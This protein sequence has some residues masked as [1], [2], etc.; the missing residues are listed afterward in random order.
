M[1]HGRIVSSGGT[2][3]SSLVKQAARRV[4]VTAITELASMLAEGATASWGTDPEEIAPTPDP[5]IKRRRLASKRRKKTIKRRAKSP[6]N[7]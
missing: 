4:V 5:A 7:R 6:K 1:I 2:M 3:D